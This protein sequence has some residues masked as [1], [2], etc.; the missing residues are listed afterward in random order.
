MI[1]EH[2]CTQTLTALHSPFTDPRSFAAVSMPLENVGDSA[3]VGAAQLVSDK[4]VL[5]DAAVSDGARRLPL[6]QPADCRYA[7]HS[8]S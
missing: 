2:V 3:Y 8:G 4:G 1:C 7:V 5:T 6:L